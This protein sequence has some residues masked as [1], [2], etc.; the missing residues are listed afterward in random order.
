MIKLFVNIRGYKVRGCDVCPFTSS[1]TSIVYFSSKPV[2]VV[3]VVV[4]RR[5]RRKTIFD[6]Q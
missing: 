5:V 4:T 2:G 6:H 3:V 1:V